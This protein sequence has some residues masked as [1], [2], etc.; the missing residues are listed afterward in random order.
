MSGYA[1]SG[2]PAR[3]SRGMMA[4]LD[5]I[6][7]HHSRMPNHHPFII[8]RRHQKQAAEWQEYGKPSP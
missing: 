4:R 8:A 5:V 7:D 3:D 2:W 6:A 1:T